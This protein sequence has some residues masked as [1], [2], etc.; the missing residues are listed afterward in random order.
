MQDGSVM[1]I[2]IPLII[3]AL[4]AFATLGETTDQCAKRYGDIIGESTT[5]S[6]IDYKKKGIITFCLFDAGK[7]VFVSHRINVHLMAD[8][9]AP[10]LTDAL[11]KNL[12]E[13][14]ATDW[15][16]IKEDEYNEGETTGYFEA[17]DGAVMALCTTY[18]VAVGNAKF[19]RQSA[20]QLHEQSLMEA[21]ESMK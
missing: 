3:S 6:R 8:D 13:L 7:C 2:L 12:L 16:K 11:R 18:S 20:D 9:P 17:K 21:I 4:P 1:K 19:L 5:G 14:H 10:K 15:K